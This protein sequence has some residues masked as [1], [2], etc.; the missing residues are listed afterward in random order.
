MPLVFLYFAAVLVLAPKPHLSFLYCLILLIPLLSR[1]ILYY[2]LAEST[3]EVGPAEPKFA[4][5]PIK[6]YLPPHADQISHCPR[7]YINGLFYHL[8]RHPQKTAN[9]FA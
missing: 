9:L 2:L 8:L 4:E 5:T 7:I 6:T 1:N 3:L